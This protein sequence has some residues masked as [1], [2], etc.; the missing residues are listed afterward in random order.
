MVRSE[1][2]PPQSAHFW[3]GRVKQV[4]GTEKAA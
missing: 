4:Y 2:L 1:R 3:G